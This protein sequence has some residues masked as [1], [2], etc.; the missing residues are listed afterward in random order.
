VL[1]KNQLESYLP[2]CCPRDSCKVVRHT[3][4]IKR[5]CRDVSPEELRQLDLIIKKIGKRA[6]SRADKKPN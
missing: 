3:A 4:P 2:L 1:K 6:E 5:V